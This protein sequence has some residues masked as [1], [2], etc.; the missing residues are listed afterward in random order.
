MRR[1]PP[2]LT[3]SP[4]RWAWFNLTQAYRF[5]PKQSDIVHRIA[6]AVRATESMQ[7][8][9][10]VRHSPAI[11]GCHSVNHYAECLLHGACRCRVNL[12]ATVQRGL[13]AGPYLNYRRFRHNYMQRFNP[14]F[15][16]MPISYNEGNGCSSGVNSVAN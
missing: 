9:W 11:R 12:F 16:E 10:E 13:A 15:Y 14:V 5:K 1:V 3:T 4:G 7:Q 2:A 6:F 8:F